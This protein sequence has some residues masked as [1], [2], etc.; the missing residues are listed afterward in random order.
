MSIFDLYLGEIDRLIREGN[1]EEASSW[2]SRYLEETDYSQESRTAAS[3]KF[4]EISENLM[5]K[6]EF[7]KALDYYDSYLKL[8]ESFLSPEEYKNAI[9]FAITKCKWIID[10][11]TN[12]DS[13]C[14]ARKYFDRIL[15]YGIK[16]NDTRV[17]DR[18]LSYI[19]EKCEEEMKKKVSDK[20][21][22]ERLKQEANKYMELIM[23]EETRKGLNNE[24]IARDHKT[25]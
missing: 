2:L 22:L 15:N 17:S 13:F 16:L 1:F 11:Q 3:W 6:R 25:I 23:D 18:I 21:A 14:V 5:K 24:E 20:G 12:S 19:I 4:K 7:P 9:I 8:A 10:V